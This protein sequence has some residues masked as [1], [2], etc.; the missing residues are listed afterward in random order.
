MVLHPPSTGRGITSAKHATL[1]LKDGLY[2][3]RR[4]RKPQRL[5]AAWYTSVLIVRK[6]LAYISAFPSDSSAGSLTIVRRLLAYVSTGHGVASAQYRTWR[7]K[8]VG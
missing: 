4:R 6:S 7:R 5:I 2:R 8:G 3:S 1:P